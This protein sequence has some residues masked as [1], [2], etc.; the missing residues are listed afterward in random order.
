MAATSGCGNVCDGKNPDTYVA[1]VDGTSKKCATD[2]VTLATKGQVEL[3]YSAFCRTAWA[4][5][6]DPGTWSYITIESYSGSTL[7][8]RYKASA[9]WTP[10]VNDKNLV[11]RGCHYSYDGE[12]EAAAGGTGHLDGCTT[13]H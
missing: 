6:V 5:D 1:T 13:K 4:R 11:A 2:A 3:R 9:A 8:K 7:R 10:M 12:D